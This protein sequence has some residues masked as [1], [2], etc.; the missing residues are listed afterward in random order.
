MDSI[1]QARLQLLCPVV[2]EKF[3]QLLS[4]LDFDV[5]LVQGLR[6]WNDQADLY[7]KGRTAPGEP[8]SHDGVARPVDT[9]AEHPLGLIVTKCRP[10][11]SYHQFGL[12]G[13]LCPDILEI[14]GYQPDWNAQH[15]TWKR[16]EDAGRSCGFIC[17]CDFRTFVDAPHFQMAGRFPVNPDDEVRQLFSDG[18]CQ[19]VWDEA[20]R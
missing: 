7:A 12:A 13:D 15:Q 6:S 4:I 20:F 5:R 10:G 8:C 18:G 14:P 3:R 17:G 1:T 11:H 2:A 16:L 19:A 9:C